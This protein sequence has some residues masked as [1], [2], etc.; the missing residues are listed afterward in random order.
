MRLRFSSFTG[1]VLGVIAVLVIAPAI[2]AASTD[3]MAMTSETHS[4][5][6]HYSSALDSMPSH[7]MLLN[8][9][10]TQVKT[11]RFVLSAAESFSWYPI[12][13]TTEPAASETKYVRS[14][15]ECKIPIP[16]SVE[17]HC[18]NFLSSEEPPL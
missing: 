3:T 8:A 18:R 13:L 2:C 11:D 9:V 7:H 14:D 1:V 16:T 6:P 17:Y 10:G 5:V 12:N 4:D 15:I